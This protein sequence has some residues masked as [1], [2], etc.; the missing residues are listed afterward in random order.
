[1]KTYPRRPGSLQVAPALNALA[2]CVLGFG[3]IAVAV[4]LGGSL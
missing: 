2:L 3:A 4:M 1:M